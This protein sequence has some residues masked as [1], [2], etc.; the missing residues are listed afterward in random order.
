MKR[1]EDEQVYAFFDAR[2]VDM[3]SHG[4]VFTA[5]RAASVMA[6][7]MEEQALRPF[8]LTH[9][10]YRVLSEL[11]IKGALELRDLAAFMMVSRPSIVGTVDTLEANGLVE[12]TRLE[13]DRR[14]VQVAITKQGTECIEHADAAW[15]AAQVQVTSGLSAAEK[16]QLAELNNRVFEAAL[17]LRSEGAAV[18]GR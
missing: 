12:R 4:A 16:R 11:W 7:T 18:E 2:G 17:R 13:S 6:N 3:D 8:G 9:A 1:P 15:H 5:I 14:L 10:G